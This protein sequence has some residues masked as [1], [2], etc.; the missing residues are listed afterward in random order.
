MNLR[1][2]VMIYPALIRTNKSRSRKGENSLAIIIRT[3]R[4]GVHTVP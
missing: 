2:Q 3:C 1:Y 4:K